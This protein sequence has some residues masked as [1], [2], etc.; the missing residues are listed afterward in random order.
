MLIFK[1]DCLG[2]ALRFEAGMIKFLVGAWLFDCIWDGLASRHSLGSISLTA[3]C[4][5]A[6]GLT[7]V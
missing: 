3:E 4:V 2:N 6:F 5:I 1:L 7:G